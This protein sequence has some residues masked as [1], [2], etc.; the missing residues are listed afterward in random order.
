MKH[1]EHTLTTRR[2]DIEAMVGKL[3]KPITDSLWQKL[4][5]DEVEFL[6]DEINGKSDKPGK[7]SQKS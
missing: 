6:R 2:R 7:P 3:P 1:T 4:W 5:K